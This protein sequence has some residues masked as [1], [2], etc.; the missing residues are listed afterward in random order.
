MALKENVSRKRSH[1][2]KLSIVEDNI[3]WCFSNRQFGIFVTMLLIATLT[4]AQIWAAYTA[5]SLALFSDS[6]S[7][8]IDTV[9]YAT[10]LWAECVESEQQQ[11]NQLIATPLSIFALLSFTGYVLYSSCNILL[12][13]EPQEDDVN[14]YIVFGFGAAG[15]VLDLVGLCALGKGK[16]EKSTS[17]GDLNLNSAKIHIIADVMRNLTCLVDSILIWFYDF[18]ST[19]TDAWATLIVSG[20]IILCCAEMIREWLKVYLRYRRRDKKLTSLLESEDA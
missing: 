1:T 14:S 10:N 4:S 13:D 19:T 6:G 17:A 8:A 20:L 5:K 12:S 9:S 18:E 3:M 15:M 11:R 16:K 7:M 2:Y